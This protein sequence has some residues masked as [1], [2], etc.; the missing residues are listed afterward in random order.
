[1]EDYYELKH[2]RAE[3]E[4]MDK[5][6][7]AA[8]KDAQTSEADAYR[9]ARLQ[10]QGIYVNRL[11]HRFREKYKERSWRFPPETFDIDVTIKRPHLSRN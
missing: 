11:A 6:D 9:L 10:R 4:R 5:E 7:K 2:E 3:Y 8:Y 1:M